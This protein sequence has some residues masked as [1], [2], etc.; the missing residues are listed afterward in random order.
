PEDSECLYANGTR[1]SPVRN[2]E[3]PDLERFPLFAK[4]TPIRF[5]QEPGEAVYLPALWW[6]ATRMLTLSIAV[7]STFAHGPHW[8]TMIDDVI[9]HHAPNG[10][11]RAAVLGTYLRAA[12]RVKR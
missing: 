10:G 3:N 6:H 5:V 7:S 1:L 12:A 4:A 9:R 8:E 11:A 2:L